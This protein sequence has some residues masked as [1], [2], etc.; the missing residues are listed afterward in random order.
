M[1]E[2]PTTEPKPEEQAGSSASTANGPSAPEA[3]PS[4]DASSDVSPEVPP[5]TPPN[6]ST[7]ASTAAFTDAKAEVAKLKDQLLRTAADFDNYRKRTRK[8]I[9]DARKGGKEEL[10]K[11][12][13]PVFDNLERGMYSAQRAADV[14][15]VAEGL[16]MVLRQFTDTLGRQG[17]SR[18]QTVG[19]PF[20]PSVHEAIQQVESDEAAGTVVAEVQSGYVQSGRLVRAALVVVAT[21]KSS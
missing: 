13:L 9:D 1:S 6:L 12:F 20:D 8:E 19:H 7:D 17:I 3:L 14:N 18:V 21:P 4:V 10:L 16:S 11:D 2:S 15:A 5:G